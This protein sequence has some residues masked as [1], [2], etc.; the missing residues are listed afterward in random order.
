MKAEEEAAMTEEEWRATE[1]GRAYQSFRKYT[2]SLGMVMVGGEVGGWITKGIEKLGNWMADNPQ[3]TGKPLK[4]ESVETVRRLDSNHQQSLRNSLIVIAG[5]GS[6]EGCVE[7][8]VKATIRDDEALLAG[9]KMNPERIKQKHSLTDADEIMDRQWRALQQQ[10]SSNLP[11]SQKFE[12]L[13]RFVGL[14]GKIPPLVED[15]FNIAYA[16][17]NVWAHNAGIADHTFLR[18][19]PDWG[20]SLDDCVHV[21]LKQATFCLSA[22]ITYGFIIL[23]RNRAAHGLGPI[24]N[25]G[26][27]SES[28]LGQAYSALYA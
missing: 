23:N 3:V 16:I 11:A 19:A 9:T 26:K 21:E 20:V 12:E 6:F 2:E 28:P 4:P 27:P 10:P 17:R 18:R 1:Q 22:I 13:L 24:P 8:V 14:N 5:W 7:D 25:D 15:S